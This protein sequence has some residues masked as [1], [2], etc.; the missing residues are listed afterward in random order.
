MEYEIHTSNDELVHWG[1][2]GMRWGVR[3]YQNKDGSLTTA[4]KKRYNAELAKVRQEEKT[5]KNRQAVKARMERLAARKKAVEQGNKELDGDNP[6]SKFGFKKNKQDNDETAATNKTVKKSIKDMTDEEL[7]NAVNRARLEAEYNRLRPEQTVE[8]HPFMKKMVNDAVKP[9][10]INAGRDFLQKSIT[11]AGENLLKG[12]A[13]PNSLEA[14]TKIRDKLKITNEINAL[15]QDPDSLLS[16]GDRIKKQTWEKNERERE[17]AAADAKAESAKAAADEAARKA[18]EAT[19]QQYY[20]S[21]YNSG[22]SSSRNEK[23]RVNPDQ[24]IAL[25]VRNTPVTSLSKTSV[26]SGKSTVDRHMNDSIYDL[27]DKNG[28]TLLSFGNEDDV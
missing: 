8:K 3:R 25:T 9:A 13:D 28:N 26:S 2:R 22:Q 10:V 5:L 17:K 18:N 23:T 21:T 24:S 11:K 14:L 20:N 16:W 12:K 27:L 6:K 7:F 4:G 1:V 15:K 19:S